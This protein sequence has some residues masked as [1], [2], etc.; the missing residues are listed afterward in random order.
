MPDKTNGAD[1]LACAMTAGAPAADESRV[2]GRYTAVCRDADGTE[3]WRAEFDNLLTEYGKALLLDQGLAGAAY[4]AAE[5]MGLISSTSFSAVSGGDTMGSHAGWL[6]AGSAN[7]P[8]YS[9]NRGSCAWSA[10]TV[11]GAAAYSATKSL[12]AGLTFTF[13]GSGTVEGAFIVAGA[14][15]S[16]TVGNTGGTLFSAGT[17]GTAQ[18]VISGNTLTLSY[19]ATLT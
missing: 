13:T 3:L 6:E 5:Y 7:A 1:A 18:P 8:T 9:G 11:S 10:A 2:L 14:G 16:A 4:T 12:S 17:L 19:S 15:A